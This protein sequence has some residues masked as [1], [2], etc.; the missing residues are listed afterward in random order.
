M[1]S[2]NL[3][4]PPFDEVLHC[5]P[6]TR[7]PSDSRLLVRFAVHLYH[8]TICA[9][10]SLGTTKMT[11]FTRGFTKWTGGHRQICSACMCV[12]GESHTQSLRSRRG[13][14]PMLTNT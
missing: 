10:L 3:V 1:L 9:L 12:R 14:Y 5:Y 8:E 13:A 7:A 2:D 4:G 11:L 6:C